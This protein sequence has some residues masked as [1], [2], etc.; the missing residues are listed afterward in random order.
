MSILKLNTFHEKLNNPTYDYRKQVHEIVVSRTIKWCKQ[1]IAFQ[2]SRGG[3]DLED[4]P[5]DYKTFNFEQLQ[6]LCCLIVWD[7]GWEG[8]ETFCR[9]IKKVA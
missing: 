4:L 2:L 1:F 5:A 3:V 9:K 7:W 8:S 6:Q